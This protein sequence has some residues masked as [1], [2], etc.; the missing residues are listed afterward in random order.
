MYS[1]VHIP[2]ILALDNISN[3]T[4]FRKPED[5]ISSAINKYL[6]FDPESIDNIE[7]AAR[8]DSLLYR[9]YLDLATKNHKHLYI[10][11]FEDITKNTLA[12]FEKIAE[13]FDLPLAK[14]Y[15][16][17]FGELRMSGDLWSNRHDGHLPREKYP[18][19]LF[20]EETVANLGFI[21]DLNDEYESFISNYVTF[22]S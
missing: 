6:Q 22:T 12:H 15:G 1:T 7:G 21:Q 18:D 14:D 5:A 13:K 2:E 9:E 11:Q 19:R 10:A 4:V 17:K 20:I 3:V 16:A 8:R